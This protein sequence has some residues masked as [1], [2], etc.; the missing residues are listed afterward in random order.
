MH[1]DVLLVVLCLNA[2]DVNKPVLN[3]GNCTSQ[4]KGLPK[5]R[6]YR[7]MLGELMACIRTHVNAGKYF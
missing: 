5:R 7:K 1:G 6:V 4:A 3:P 2:E